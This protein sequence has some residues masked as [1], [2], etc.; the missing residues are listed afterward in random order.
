MFSDGYLLCAIFFSVRES[1]LSGPRTSHNDVMVFLGG[2]QEEVVRDLHEMK[3]NVSLSE[4]PS[5]SCCTD[6][7][8]L[9]DLHSDVGGFCT[10]GGFR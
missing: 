4:H 8:C 3:S 6:R 10:P 9:F 1:W 2:F 5:V 7:S